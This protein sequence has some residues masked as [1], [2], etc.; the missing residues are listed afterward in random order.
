MSQHA[1]FFTFLAYMPNRDKLKYAAAV[2]RNMAPDQRASAMESI[3]ANNPDLANLIGQN[4]FVFEN[5]AD[6]DNRS[7]QRLLRE[8]HANSL[9][10]AL[11]GVEKDVLEKFCAGMSRRGA[12]D[13]MEHIE[14]GGKIRLAEVEAERTNILKLAHAMAEKGEIVLSS[15]DEPMVD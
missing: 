2:L 1:T 6:L 4:L 8:V 10:I 15:A 12:N 9:A 13:L 11:R 5:L 7:L 14:S 3:R